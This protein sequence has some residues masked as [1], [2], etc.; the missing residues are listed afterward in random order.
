MAKNIVKLY[1]KP[2]YGI[3]LGRS[4][5]KTEFEKQLYSLVNKKIYLRKKYLQSFC[6]SQ[7]NQ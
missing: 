5:D 4:E 3:L 7:I 2:Q 6:K 1:K